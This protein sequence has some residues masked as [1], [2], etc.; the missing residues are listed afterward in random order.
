MSIIR[1]SINNEI[2]AVQF[3]CGKSDSEDEGL[4]EKVN[5]IY[6]Q[7]TPSKKY[8]KVIYRSGTDDL[9]SLTAELLR[10]NVN[11]FSAS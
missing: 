3:W 5:A 11:A 2:K 1:V 7:I 9:V 4:F 10:T 8:K 6:N